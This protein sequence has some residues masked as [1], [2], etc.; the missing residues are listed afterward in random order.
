MIFESPDPIPKL[1]PSGTIVYDH[2]L[3]EKTAFD[4]D[5][6]AFIDGIT[7]RS[8]TRAQLRR[9]TLRLGQGIHELESGS[10]ALGWKEPVVL[11][12]SPN[13]MDYPVIFLGAQAAGCIASLVNASYLMDELAHQIR[14]STPFVIF[15]HPTLVDVLESALKLLKTEGYNTLAI[16]VYS[17]SSEAISSDKADS[18]PYPS[19]QTLYANTTSSVAVGNKRTKTSARDLDDT[20]AVLCYSSG[21]VSLACVSHDNLVACVKVDALADNPPI[22]SRLADGQVQ[23]GRDDQQELQLLVCSLERSWER[24]QGFSTKRQVCFGLAVLP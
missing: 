14:D 21:T 4:P 8:I 3:P 17:T 20:P 24:L 10:S 7:G 15:V 11:I 9:D 23:G 22:D 1:P 6:P 19:Y 16:R 18:K 5:S 2:V 12:F 13:T